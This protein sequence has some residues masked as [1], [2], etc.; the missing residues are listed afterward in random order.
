[1]RKTYIPEIKIIILK[2][3]EKIDDSRFSVEEPEAMIKTSSANIPTMAS[4]SEELSTSNIIGRIDLP[5]KLDNF[6]KLFRKKIVRKLI[7]RKNL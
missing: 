5:D 3:E 2:A 1:M 7:R 6:L 4:V